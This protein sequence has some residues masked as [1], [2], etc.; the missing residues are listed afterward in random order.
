MQYIAYAG[1]MIYYCALALPQVT[2]GSKGLERQGL[3]V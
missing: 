1:L 2:Q 3:G